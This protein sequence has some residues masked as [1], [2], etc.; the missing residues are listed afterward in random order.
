MFLYLNAFGR[1]F[2]TFTLLVFLGLA[3]F[4]DVFARPYYTAFLLHAIINSYC[5][6]PSLL[7]CYSL[8]ACIHSS[9]LYCITSHCY[10]LSLVS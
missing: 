9:L 5:Y 10:L 1:I 4:S 8:V 7:L 2:R 6:L 3:L